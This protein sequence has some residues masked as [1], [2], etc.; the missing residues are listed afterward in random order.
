[1]QDLAHWDNEY[2]N[3]NNYQI[4]ARQT[5]IYPG[6]ND[7]NILYPV[8]GLV[9]ESGEILET[10]WNNI[11]NKDQ[12]PPMIADTIEKALIACKSVESLKKDIRKGVVEF[13]KLIYDKDKMRTL[14]KPELGDNQWY[15]ADTST[16]L[17]L[18]LSIVHKYNIFKLDKRLTEG[19]IKNPELRKEGE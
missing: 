4:K 3:T 5:A 15:A 1:M 16:M 17:G 7:G 10:V 2:N 14:V 9:G 18:K 13:P 12:L 8:L 11:E 6:S 19:T